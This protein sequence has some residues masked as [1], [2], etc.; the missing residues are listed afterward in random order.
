[1]QVQK[2]ITG[3][4]NVLAGH[5]EP[6]AVVGP[7]LP[8]CRLPAHWF[9]LLCLLPGVVQSQIKYCITVNTAINVCRVQELR[10]EIVP[11]IRSTTDA[12]HAQLDGMSLAV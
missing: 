12:I 7:P 10:T 2:A 1:M 5:C 9:G 4:L 6:W 8:V 11:R 3:Q